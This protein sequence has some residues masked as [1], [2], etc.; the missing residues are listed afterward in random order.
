MLGGE[1]EISQSISEHFQ[2]SI[3]PYAGNLAQ[4]DLLYINV[5]TASEDQITTAKSH[6]LSGDTVVIDLSMIAS[7]EEKIE[8]S[9]GITGLGMSAPILV[10]GMNQGDDFINAIISDVV[11]ENDNPI[12]DAKAELASI[13]QSLVHSLTR[14][15]FGE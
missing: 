8:R 10:I 15:G 1:N 7:D 6:V 2:Q 9:Q 4:K 5:G 14:L 13:K 11:D 3:Q 12:N